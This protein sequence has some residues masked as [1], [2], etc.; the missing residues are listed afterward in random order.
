MLKL[1][2]LGVLEESTD[3]LEVLQQF[4]FSKHPGATLESGE[5]HR[6]NQVKRRGVK[7]LWVL[8]AELQELYLVCA[9]TLA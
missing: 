8:G 4:A 3:D 6:M 1:E 2:V 5:H 7:H 9:V